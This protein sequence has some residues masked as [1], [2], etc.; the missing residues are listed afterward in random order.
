MSL[1]KKNNKITKELFKKFCEKH[2]IDI[3]NNYDSWNKEI[4]I[5]Q[6]DVDELKDKSAGYDVF[7]YVNFNTV[8]IDDTNYFYKPHKDLYE[9][10][11]PDTYGTYTFHAQAILYVPIPINLLKDSELTKLFHKKEIKIK[12][13]Y[14]VG[15]PANT[16]EQ[17]EH[18]YKLFFSNLKSYNDMFN[19]DTFI[20]TKKVYLEQKE[21]IKQLQMNLK[22]L[23]TKNI[24]ILKKK[25]E[26]EQDFKE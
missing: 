21:H 1:K 7:L 19:S 13:I 26:I 24:S 25:A 3:I 10:D 18:L 6:S 23:L 22:S 9:S 2:K 5:Y 8:E 20:E 12:D 11:E 17:L 16:I 4:Y 15:V 14:E